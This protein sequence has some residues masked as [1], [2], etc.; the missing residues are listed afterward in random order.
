[1]TRPDPVALNDVA[2][3]VRLLKD[4]GIAELLTE[5]GV[6]RDCGTRCACNNSECGCRG[7]VYKLEEEELTP[8][9]LETLKKKRIKELQQQIQDAEQQIADL[10]SSRQ[11]STQD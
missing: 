2:D 3:L 5:S 4:G 10:A 1:M 11:T 9:E 7:K 6:A 8:S